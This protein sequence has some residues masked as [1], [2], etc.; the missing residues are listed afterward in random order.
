MT[1]SAGF[2][3]DADVISVYT[4]GQAIA[5]GVLID[6]TELVREYFKYPVAVTAAVWELLDTIPAWSG[7]E[8]VGARARD[9]ARMLCYQAKRQS[10]DMLLFQFLITRP[11]GGPRTPR[12]VQLKSHIGPGDDFAP[13]ITIMLPEED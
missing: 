13:V 1:E 4:R 12:L 8:E 10:G 2:W 11:G 9:M 6:I 3:D 7:Y 5:D